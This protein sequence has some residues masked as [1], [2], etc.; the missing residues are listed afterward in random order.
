ME[1]QINYEKIISDLKDDVNNKNKEISRLSLENANLK[2]E[3][4]ISKENHESLL[5]R[6]M[7]KL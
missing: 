4:K 1:I 3:L 5:D 2:L 6:V 7:D